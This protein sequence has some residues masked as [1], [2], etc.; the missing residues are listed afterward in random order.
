M[1]SDISELID[2]AAPTNNEEQE[3]DI[4]PVKSVDEEERF[5]DR[6]GDG[7]PVTIRFRMKHKYN[8]KH[9][10][11]AIETA[12]PTINEGNEEVIVLLVLLLRRKASKMETEWNITER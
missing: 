7:E 6:Y 11:K 8:K 12:A 1:E 9:V 10:V 3:E 2:T 4:I 5:E